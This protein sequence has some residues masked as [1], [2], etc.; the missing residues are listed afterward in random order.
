MSGQT[1]IAEKER[2]AVLLEDPETG[3]GGG[4]HATRFEANIKADQLERVAPS[5]TIEEEINRLHQANCEVAQQ[6]IQRAIRIGELLVKKKASLPHGEWLPWFTKNIKFSTQTADNYRMLYTRQA[7]LKF[8]TIRNLTDAYRLLRNADKLLKDK[9]RRT[10][11]VQV[12]A[13]DFADQTASVPPGTKD[14]TVTDLPSESEE[15]EPPEIWCASD[16]VEA[17][18]NKPKSRPPQPKAWNPLE[19]GYEQ[20]EPGVFYPAGETKPLSAS[21]TDGNKIEV[22]TIPPQRKHAVPR[23]NVTIDGLGQFPGIPL[24]TQPDHTAGIVS[25]SK[26]K[27]VI[28]A[29]GKDDFEPAVAAIKE[30]FA[31]WLAQWKDNTGAIAGIIASEVLEWAQEHFPDGTRKLVEDFLTKAAVV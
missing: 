24:S 17:D 13:A 6:V 8:L 5:E 23:V 19:H 11:K 31:A 20:T 29:L 27:E 2:I 10:P 18:K 26:M 9:V 21:K 25:E 22:W 3:K 12:N 15:A 14:S 30:S 4:F 7:E 16:E 28:E 1:E